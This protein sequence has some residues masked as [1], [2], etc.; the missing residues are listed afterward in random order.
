MTVTSMK[1]IGAGAELAALGIPLEE[2]LELVRM[3]R[4]NVERVANE[5]VK[6]VAEHVLDPYREQA[7]P[8]KEELPKIAELIWRLRPLAERAVTA[9]LSRAMELAAKKFLADK[10]E[11]IIVDK[12][13]GNTP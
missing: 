2:L 6:L 10:L 13:D 12:E 5:L 11:E 4:G 3:M 9:E 8:P 7:L 1:T